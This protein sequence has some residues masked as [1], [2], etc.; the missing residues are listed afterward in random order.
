MFFQQYPYN[1]RGKC[2]I[3]MNI[4][5]NSIQHL[6]STVFRQISFDTI[7]MRQYLFRG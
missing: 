5:S 3:R 7:L 4:T 2:D 6:E 1:R